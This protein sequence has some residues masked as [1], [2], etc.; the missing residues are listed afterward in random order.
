MTLSTRKL[1]TY[2]VTLQT[3]PRWTKGQK[4]GSEVSLK[5]HP[6]SGRRQLQGW[7]WA[8]QGGEGKGVLAASGDGTSPL[9]PFAGTIEV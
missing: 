3:E 7:A 4:A 9:F 6:N 8:G 2:P 5:W 1:K